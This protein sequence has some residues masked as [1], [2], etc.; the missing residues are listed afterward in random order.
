LWVNAGEANVLL[1]ADLLSGPLGCGWGAV[2][3][4]FSPAEAATLYKAAH[5]G[6]STSHHDGLWE[7]LLAIQPV[8]LLT[9]F[10]HGNVNLPES[11]DIRYFLERTDKAWTTSPRKPTPS[12]A[13]KKEASKLGTLAQ[14]PRDTYGQVGQLRARIPFAG[15]KW[16]VDNFPP[17]SPLA[18]R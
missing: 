2:L 8:V 18:R 3:H 16:T 4:A 12:K 5:H 9:P 17:A 15:D 11:S 1:G 14:D 6:S 7:K 13:F 10:R